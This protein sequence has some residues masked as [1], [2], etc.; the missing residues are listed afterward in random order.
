MV[1]QTTK[2][3]NGNIILPKEIQEFWAGAMVF[4]RADRDRITIERSGKKGGLFDKETER[5]L[6]ILGRKVTRKDI[7]NAIRWA[8]RQSK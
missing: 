7:E 1:T 4:V 6:R 2:I 8:R 3:K 5:K